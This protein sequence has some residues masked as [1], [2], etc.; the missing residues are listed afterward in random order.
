MSTSSYVA[1]PRLLADSWTHFATAS[2]FR[3]GR[4]LPMMM[5]TLIMSAATID[6]ASEARPPGRTRARDQAIEPASIGGGARALLLERFGTDQRKG[7][8]ALLAAAPRGGDQ[9][10]PR[11]RPRP[12]CR[13]VSFPP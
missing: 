1:S 12:G 5:P 7:L 11:S 13:S 9:S 6:E 2:A 4:V 3:P 8:K 10:H